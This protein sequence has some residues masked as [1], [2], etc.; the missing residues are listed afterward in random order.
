MYYTKFESL[1]NKGLKSGM[2]TEFDNEI[3]EKMSSTIISC[4]PV[5]LY[6]KYSNLLFPEG[7]CYDR[8]LY[9]FLALDDAILVRGNTFHLGYLHGTESAGH[10]WVEIGNYVYDPAHM[11]KYD[12]DFYYTLYGVSDIYK[13][14]KKDYIK[15]N[16][17]FV[18]R[19]VSHSLDDFRPGGKRRMELGSLIILIGSLSKF[20]GEEFNRELNSYL[21]LIEYNAEELYKLKDGELEKILEA[22]R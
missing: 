4:L 20:F 10:G 3:F 5:S 9:M 19:V 8:S 22:N 21:S 16:K 6:I 7:T 11:L 13:I 18:E 17:D 12:K 14:S 15:Q 1:Y 2:V